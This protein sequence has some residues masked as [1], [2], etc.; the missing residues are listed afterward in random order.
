[1]LGVRIFFRL[2]LVKIYMR[3][4]TNGVLQFSQQAWLIAI[5][6]LLVNHDG[7]NYAAEH[8]TPNYD[9]LKR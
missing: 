5:A 9:K 6:V 2:L 1:M 7:A 3:I 8:H 4:K